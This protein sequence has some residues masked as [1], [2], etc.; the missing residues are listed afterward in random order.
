MKYIDRNCKNMR[1]DR[2]GYLKVENVELER[3]EAAGRF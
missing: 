3:H 2:S 1:K